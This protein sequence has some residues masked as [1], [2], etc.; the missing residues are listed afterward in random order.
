MRKQVDR[1]RKAGY[2]A[3]N[4]LVSGAIIFRKNASP[5]VKKINE[6]WWRE[7]E[8]GSVRDQ[9]SFDYVAWKNTFPFFRIDE[10]V[11]SNAYEEMREHAFE[12]MHET[13]Y[14]KIRKFSLLFLIRLHKRLKKARGLNFT[15]L[16]DLFQRG[17]FVLRNSGPFVFCRCSYNYLVYGREYFRLRQESLDAEY[18]LWIGENERLD[19]EKIK[20]DL[21]KFRYKPKISI[22]TPVYNVQAQWLDLCVESVRRQLYENWEL[23]LYDDAST[24]PE[25]ITCLKKLEKFGDERIKIVYGTENQHISGASNVALKL[26]T[27]EFVALL[28]HDDEL[29][30]NALHEIVRILNKH[31]KADFIYSDEDKMEENGTRA[32][33]F[34]K[35]D[36]SLE[37]L[38]T[39][40][41]IT[42]LSVFRKSILDAIGGFRNGYDGSQDYDIILRTVERTTPEKIFHV[43]KI[44]YHWRKVS[45]STALSSDSKNYAYVAAKKALADYLKRNDMRGK[46]VDGDSTGRYRIKIKTDWTAKILSTLRFLWTRS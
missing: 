6:D 7:I 8:S 12:D 32:E 41:Y 33:P 17:F 21:W 42:H 5:T 18:A 1:Y 11:R 45:G 14:E 39:M 9:L 10:S 40:N 15:Y 2:P 46:I 38:L 23:C 30:A 31:P 44:L 27:G 16:R 28:D 36:F 43:P 24:N 3:D 35:P 34:F 20:D 4:G 26:A 25:T 13:W 29:S 19:I 37:L 22:I